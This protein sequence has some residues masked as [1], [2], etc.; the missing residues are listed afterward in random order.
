MLI[1]LDSFTLNEIRETLI[2]IWEEPR[3]YTG[4]FNM[5]NKFT[6]TLSGCYTK[7]INYNIGDINLEVTNSK[8]DINNIINF[9]KK[10]MNEVGFKHSKKTITITVMSL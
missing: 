10:V 3:K 8:F 6:F 4:T 5:T 7:T 9:H 1:S 2:E